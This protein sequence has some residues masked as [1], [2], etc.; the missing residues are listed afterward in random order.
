M[1]TVQWEPPV[2]VM[3]SAYRACTACMVDVVS[4][5]LAI[6]IAALAPAAFRRW[7]TQASMYARSPTKEGAEPVPLA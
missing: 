4:H 6:G 2:A 5:A 7:T 3:V 1:V